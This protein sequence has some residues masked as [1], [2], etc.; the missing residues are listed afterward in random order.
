[1]ENKFEKLLDV[2]NSSESDVITQLQ[3]I[4]DFIRPKQSAN[5]NEV[6]NKIDFLVDYLHTH[7]EKSMKLSDDLNHW[8]TKSKISNNLSTFGV[9]SKDG[10]KNEITNRFYNKFLPPAPK[11]GDFK[12]LFS[13][14]FN[15]KND[16][17]WVENLDDEIWI[18]FFKSL[19]S[20]SENIQKTKNYLF[21]ELLYALEI[22]AIWIASEEF[23]ENFIRLDNSILSKDSSFIALQREISSFVNKVQSSIIDIQTKK[24]DFQHILVLVEQ[25]KLYV[26]ALKKKSLNLGTSVSLTYEFE[27]LEQIIKRLEE[28]F[29][30]IKIFDTDE[31]YISLVKLFKVAVRKNSTR[32][33]ILEIWQQNIKILARSITNN[34]S[35]HGEQY[36]TNNKSQ[37]IKMLLSASGAGIAIA[38]MALFKIY[39]VD[40]KLPYFI[41]TLLISL[42]YGIGFVIIHI[43]GFTVATKQPAMT[44][45]TF[46]S[47]VEKGT[48]HKANQLK[49]VELM[50]KVS[51]SQFAAVVGNVTFAL[52]VA[53][54]VGYYFSYIGMP[55]LSDEDAKY[56]LGS[57]E[58]IPALIYAAIAGIWLFYSGLIAG[59]FDNRANYLNLEQR[60]LHHK[61]LKKLFSLDKRVKLANYLHQH[62]GAIAGNFFLGILLGFTPFVGYIFDL[63]LDVRHV[64]LSTAYL[65]YGMSSIYLPYIDFFVILLFILMIGF[66]NLT[67]SFILALRVA[68]NA[69]NAYFGSVITFMRLFFCEVAKR[70]KDLFLPPKEE[71]QDNEVK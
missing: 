12:Y 3:S 51:R 25:S 4:I 53:F 21:D 41:E 64:T 33:S 14:I 65:G 50:I 57:F 23:D 6:A 32:N 56:H 36:I 8:L 19:L 68:L 62:H 22:L 1:M 18:K 39:I 28:I 13:L 63:P 43:L 2:L 52:M 61:L 47:V 58:P 66:V 44:A 17:L 37:Y 55:I 31:F 30:L 9:L 40:L 26:S 34:A 70:P 46:A 71:V 24:E 15:H 49:L 48:N 54:L 67:V 45:S 10:F 20:K 29:E 27:R 5:N 11:D 16:H 59:Y 69:R 42:D 7:Q 35:E 60:Y 38:F